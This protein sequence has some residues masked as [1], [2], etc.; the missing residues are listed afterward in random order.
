MK[1]MMQILLFLASLVLPA[2]AVA[3]KNPKIVSIL[4]AM[5][6]RKGKISNQE[7][8]A[9]VGAL[10]E[11]LKL[12]EADGFLS[13]LQIPPKKV[14]VHPRNRYGFGVHANNV[15]RLGAQIVAMGWSWAACAMAICVGETSRRSISSFTTKLQRGTK[16]LGKSNPNEIEYGSLACG[17]SNQFLIACLDG[18]PTDQPTLA[19][20]D[21]CISMEKVLA[22]DKYGH[23]KE[24]LEKGMR[25]QIIDPR[26]EEMYGDALPNL[27][28]RARQAVGQVQNEESL[29]ELCL[30]CNM[31]AA[32]M[33]EKEGDIPDYDVVEEIVGQSQVKNPEDIPRACA[34]VQLYGGGKKGQYIKDLAKFVALCVPAQRTIESTK[35]TAFL[36]LKLEASELCPEFV[37]AVLKMDYDAPEKSVFNHVCRFLKETHI[38]SFGND[39][40]AEMIE[41]NAHLRSFHKFL[42]KIEFHDDDEETLTKGIGDCT[43]GRIVCELPVPA[44]FQGLTVVQALRLICS[45]HIKKGSNLENP[46]GPPDGDDENDG[47]KCA[48]KS[49]TSGAM[50]GLVEYDASGRAHGVD[51]NTLQA[52]GFVV[53]TDVIRQEGGLDCNRSI[54][55]GFRKHDFNIGRFQN[56]F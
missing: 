44:K 43:V 55:K 8:S 47:N 39:K 50:F 46:F 45:E 27:V 15:H 40:K 13:K 6:F 36:K 20:P 10:D 48:P 24:A 49:A 35:L 32:A 31:V 51:K 18:V 53:G 42:A 28:Q 29:L 30:E 23:M 25:W 26:A 56:S 7:K 34:F 17:H 4:E 14:G 38:A 33:I 9:I 41:A 11:V 12:L 16:K 37:I 2:A 3:P 5:S 52:Q 19:G 1:I 22:T 54:K 21:G